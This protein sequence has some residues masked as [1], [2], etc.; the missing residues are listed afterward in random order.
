MSDLP[1]WFEG[2]KLNFAENLLRYRND[3]VAI[4]QD[5]EDSEIEKFTFAQMYEEVK[6]YSAAF[7]K[8]GLKKG[9]RVALPS[10]EKVIIVASK[11]NSYSKDISAIRNSCFLNEFLK[12][13]Y[14]KD[15]SVPEIQFEQVSFSHPVTIS[16]TSGTT[17]LPKAIIHGCGILM[18]VANAYYI[19]FDGDRGWASWTI[20]STLFFLGHTLVLFEGSPYYLSPTHMWD[21]IQKHKISNIF[22][23]SSVIDEFQKRGFVPTEKHD[24]SSLKLVFAGGSVVKPASYD[25]IKEILKGITFTASYGNSCS[26]KSFET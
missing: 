17:G 18:A 16:Y 12:L 5:G 1:K 26:L 8:F 6:L 9:D 2:S 4:I 25:F 19:N 11:P 7:R 3:E 21:L 15:G 20:N 22:F 13:G 14:E 10:L 23:P 24:I